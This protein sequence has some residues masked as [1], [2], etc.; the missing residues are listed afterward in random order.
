MSTK[1]SFQLHDVG[2]GA[3]KLK[4]DDF[5]EEKPFIVT[6][7]L[8]EKNGYNYFGAAFNQFVKWPQNPIAAVVAGDLV[9]VYEFP[10]NEAKMKLIKSEKYQFK[11]TENQA[12]WAV[13]WCCLG[14]DQYKIV[15][16]CESGRLFVI[17]FT[18][19]EIEK[20]FNDCGGAITDIRTSPITPS[21]VAVSSDDKAV[22]IFDIR[23]TAALIICGG[24]RFHQDRVQSVD[25][26]PDG[27]EVVSSGIDHRV[28]CWDLSTKRVQ[29]HL[30]YCAG[31]L[32]QGLE[33]EPTNEYAGN[34]RLE[35][36][37][38]VFNPKGYTLF[39]LSPSH[40]ITN[41][42]H[43]GVFRK[44]HRNYLLSKACGK[45][46]AISFWRFG[47]YGDVKENLEDGEPATSHVKIGA[48]SLKG[49]FEWFCKFGV[50]PLRKYIGVGGRGGHLQFHDLQNWEQEEPAL[51][52]KFKTKAIR[53]VVFSDQGRI[54][55]V[56]GDGGFLCR[57]D[58]VQ[59]GAQQTRNIWN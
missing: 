32:D 43:D 6:Y 52:I 59:S 24:A 19:M 42:H 8:L 13:A 45:E 30:E 17:D 11:F 14:A 21:L 9:K 23:A 39:I 27:K 1:R 4:M 46:S 16:G 58:R 41:L 51:S 36:A 7:H 38:R 40:S 12:F 25:W 34:G 29:D 54:V 44:N 33:I 50:D 5:N 20:D 18:T 57:L 10:V 31:F 55:L 47:T 49:G 37:R 26:T 35:Q 28:M 53:Q 3:K 22:R 15:A 2:S 56:T 48:K